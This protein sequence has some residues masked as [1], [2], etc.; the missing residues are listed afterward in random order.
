MPS[1]LTIIRERR[2]RRQVSRRSGRQRSQRLVLGVGFVLTALILVALLAAA[3]TYAG[4]TRGLPPV[5]QLPVLLNPRDG[6][7]LQPTRFFDRSGS[8]LLASLSPDSGPRTY[9]LYDQFPKALVDATVLLADPNYWREPGF[10]VAGWQDPQKH[11]TLAQKLVSDLLLWDEPPS[12]GRA[13]HERMLAAQATARYGRQQV[14]EWYLNSAD[15]GRYAYGAETAARLYFGKSV[16]QL[17]LSEA[18]LLAAVGHAP[19]LNPLDAPQAAETL[20][21]ETL[22]IMR[23]LGVITAAQ[24]DQAKSEIPSI[25]PA[26]STGSE[27]VAPAFVNLALDQLGKRFDRARVARGGLEIVTSLDYDLQL[28]ADCLVKTE[29]VRLAGSGTGNASQTVQT[30]PAADGSDCVAAH[31]LPGLPAGAALPSASASAMILDPRTGQVLAAVGDLHGGQE[32]SLLASHPAGTLITPFVYLTGFTRGLNPATLGWDIPSGAPIPGVDYQGPVR[33]RIAL[34]NDYPIP[35]AQVLD[36]M[37]AEAVRGIAASFGLEFPPAARLLQ[38]D[39][40]L[41]LLDVAGAY[42]IFADQGTQAGQEL[43]GPSLHPVAVLKV[44]GADH[45]AWADWS[46]PQTR[47]VVSPQLAYLMNQV[48]S[49]ETARWPSLGHPNPLE[50]GR[51]AGAK[52]ART[53]DS[54]AAWVAGYT[55]QRVV[56]VWMGSSASPAAAGS[57]SGQVGPRLV[58]AVWHGLMQAAVG[59]LP[60]A[61]WEMPSGMSM[62]QVC[63][64]SGLLPTL[65][66]PNVVNEIFL[67]GREPVQADSLYQ[68][69]QVNRETGLL[70]TVFTPSEL[71]EDRVYMVVPPE[72][73][74][75]AQTKNIPAPPTAYD[76]IQ[77]PPPLPEAHITSPAMFADGRGEITVTGSAAGPDFV[78]YRLEYG[79]GLNPR[80]WIQVGMDAKTAV[81]EGTLAI[82]DTSSLNGLY[83]LRLLVVR[84][85]QR[86]D[87]AVVQ[88]TLD[89]T[90][91]QVTVTSPQD[92]Q[93]ISAAQEAQLALQAQVSDPFL[94]QVEF[95]IDD[96]KVGEFTSGPFGLLWSPVAGGHTFRV[97]AADRAGNTAEAQVHFSVNP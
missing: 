41:S 10:L 2:H 11:P 19:A 42:G 40:P 17:D 18:A 83:A 48:L 89:N 28:Q 8:H 24:A 57:G 35:A 1:T 81:E 82:W 36:Q 91:P 63:D 25:R 73:R 84:A 67:A 62:V 3:L 7:L 55:P 66:C 85:D 20:R 47:A 68:T 21:L 29:L 43:S 96:V 71:V 78:S 58:T 79:R 27:Q 37:G 33:L 22:Q 49:D 39:F 64:P 94:T 93:A 50:I 92:G 88:V 52:A 38:D 31:L 26:A 90:P 51:P 59:D 69:V 61:G 34:V 13:I 6:L 86:I 72:A 23:T 54:A 75:W 97:T 9:I 15:Y 87:Q 30:V 44:T 56:V 77:M 4:L 60:S 12:V 32:D 95:F 74:Q 70:A 5:E 45:S 53:L 65:A 46:L 80:E 16:T 14:L 76:T